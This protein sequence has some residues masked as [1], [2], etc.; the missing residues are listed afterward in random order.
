MFEMFS[1]SAFFAAFPVRRMNNFKFT[2]G[3]KAVPS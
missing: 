3:E 2:F 1:F